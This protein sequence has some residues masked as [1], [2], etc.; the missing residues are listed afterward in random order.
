MILYTVACMSNVALDFVTTYIT[1]ET[2]MEEL[3]FRTYFG[4]KLEDVNSFTVKFETYGMQRALAENTFT[5]AF[6][7]T[8]LIP[9]LIEW[10]PTITLP[11]VLGKLIVKS[12][13]E[14][15]GLDAEAWMEML[16]M[17]MGRYADILLNII[18]AVLIFYFPGGYT[19]TL[20]LGLAGS[21]MWIYAFDYYKVL[22]QIP[23]ISYVNFDLEWWCQALLAPIVGIMA[24][25]LVFKSNCEAGY[26]CLE[27][28]RLIA[29]CFAAWLLHVVVHICLL[30]Y[31]LP[32]CGKTDPK[33]ESIQGLTYA[34]TAPRIAANWFSTNP[35]NCLRSKYFYEHSPP[36]DFHVLGKERLQRTNPRIGCYFNTEAV[37]SQP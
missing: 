35:V 5:Y 26:H 11:Y 12:H 17:D 33:L 7:S 13:P 9:F 6:P 20:F 34:D 15:R 10:I 29:A 3:G 23:A 14:V 16:P 28:W 2:I 4:V 36:C 30:V 21:H 37:K 22:R 8:F 18:L 31:G 27:G 19:W 1:A 24:S 32:L 25:C